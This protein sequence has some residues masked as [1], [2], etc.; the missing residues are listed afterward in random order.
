[1][2]EPPASSE[3]AQGAG[4]LRAHGVVASTQYRVPAQ[5]IGAREGPLASPADPRVL[6]ADGGD[7]IPVRLP[8]LPPCSSVIVAGPP[9]T[10]VRSQDTRRTP[11]DHWSRLSRPQQ[12]LVVSVYKSIFEQYPC[13]EVPQVV[14]RNL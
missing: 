8:G 12:A 10:H 14:L 11:G 3:D 5:V 4:V 1:M 6:E 13:C 2:Q 7:H 9:L